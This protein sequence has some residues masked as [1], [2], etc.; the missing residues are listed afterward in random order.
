MYICKFSSL[1]HAPA[2]DPLSFFFITSSPV[3]ISSMCMEHQILYPYA[4][5][6]LQYQILSFIHWRLDITFP[7]PYVS[8]IMRIKVVTSEDQNHRF[9][10][11]VSCLKY[12][13]LSL[14]MRIIASDPWYHLKSL[15]LCPL[16]VRVSDPAST[17]VSYSV[18]FPIPLVLE[19]TLC[20]SKDHIL[21]LTY[22]RATDLF[23]VICT[24]ATDAFMPLTHMY[25]APEFF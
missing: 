19:H 25:E 22:N 18:R 16:L 23:I 24:V 8:D 7:A 20:M 3:P 17:H 10:F 6:A 14:S 5:R 15:C 4:P 21:C 12:Q 11:S 2:L 1:K 9:V 13:I